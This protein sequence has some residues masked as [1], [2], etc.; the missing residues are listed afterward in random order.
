M[1]AIITYSTC[2]CRCSNSYCPTVPLKICYY[3]RPSLNLPLISTKVKSTRARISQPPQSSRPIITQKSWCRK[4]Q[5]TC[6]SS[7]V[8]TRSKSFPTDT[9]LWL[10]SLRMD[11][12]C[13]FG[14]IWRMSS[15]LMTYHCLNCSLS[16][17]RSQ[18]VS[19][20]I[21]STTRST[22]E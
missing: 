14:L 21:S 20:P 1:W 6:W 4:I 7:T 16:M 5:P 17:P 13:F 19:R 2:C 3:T 9:D 15:R 11:I 18:E 12:L 22:T 8:K 10:G